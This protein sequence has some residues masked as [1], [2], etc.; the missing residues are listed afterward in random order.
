MGTRSGFTLIEVSF[1][2]AITGLLFLGVTLGVQNSIYQQRYND[3]VQS[4]VEFLRTVYAE[5]MNVQSIGDG[6]SEQAIYGKL[7]TFGEARNPRGE[8]SD[9]KTIFMYDV[10]G[11]VNADSATGSVF[12]VLKN[13]KANV[14]VADDDGTVRPAGIVE[15]YNLKWSADLQKTN[16]TDQYK[17]S[18][19]VVRHPRSGTV[20]TYGMD[21]VIEVGEKVNGLWDDV[22]TGDLL[23]AYLNK[24]NGFREMQMDF[25]I[26]PSGDTGRAGRADVRIG[27][28][29]RSSSAIETLFDSE[30]NLC[31]RTL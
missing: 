31:R 26:S 25:C 9:G 1:F 30:D 4:F 8:A 22:S 19:L 13:V 21:K 10:V 20:Y 7:V 18:L 24:E 6:R 5:T 14:L 29:A 27:E 12:E 11:N 3:T 17:G 15:S 2:L 28:G 23:T 16:N